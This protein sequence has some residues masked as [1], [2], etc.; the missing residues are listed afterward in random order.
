[1]DI[2]ELKS[3]LSR[4]HIRPN[5]RLGQNFLLSENVLDQIVE[6][7]EL[8]KE[9]RVLEIGPGLG[10]LTKRLADSAGEV[11]TIEKDRKLCQVLREILKRYKNVEIIH[12]D[13]LHN[14]NLANRYANITNSSYD[15]HTCSHYSNY[16]LVA[17][18]P[19][20]L[21]GKILQNF[22]A[23]EYQP[24]L[25][26]LL[27]QKEVALRIIAKPGKMSLL[28]VS[29]QFYSE[30]EI[31]SYVGRENFYPPP[32]VDSA[33]VK[34]K[35][36][37]KPRFASSLNPSPRAGEGR[38]R[39]IDE[40]EFFRLVKIGFRSKRKQ[41]QNNLSAVFGRNNYKKILQELRINPLARAQDLSLEEW[42]RLYEKLRVQSEK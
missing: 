22:L 11:I 6:A 3:L 13:A 40:K 7:A 38:E 9:D 42:R 1:M 24:Q 41:L 21:T 20:Y 28:S 29:V 36:L 15:S 37:G 2:D 17:N 34:L 32:E 8:K 18:I 30:P 10:F 16:K 26:V 39:G 14:A 4:F 12:G 33:I 35:V 25:M 19:Y 5:K 31:I 27:L 23:S